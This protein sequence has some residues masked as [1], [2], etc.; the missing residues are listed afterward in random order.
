M[1]G[2]SASVSNPNTVLNTAV[3][4]VLKQFADELESAENFETALHALIKRVITNH[5]RIVFNGNGYDD[6]WI[7]EAE[8]RGLLNLKT[9]PDA[10]PYYVKAKNIRLFTEPKAFTEKEIFS[11]HEIYL[12]SYCNLISIE[13]KTMLDMALKDILPAVSKY[14]GVLCDTLLAKK[15]VCKKLNNAYE[16]DMIKKIADLS[17]KAYESAQALEYA[18]N[19]AE[20]ISDPYTRSVY[21]KDFVLSAMQRLRK[22]ANGLE[23]VVS[24]EFWP[25]PTYGDLLFEI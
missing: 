7:E 6:A 16:K 23:G 19:E 15:S 20:R 12:R 5:K 17:A 8:R 9:T 22:A 3:A 25:F 1:L 13:A 14:S 18:V 11:R 24:A 21:Y 10:M 2:S 4:E